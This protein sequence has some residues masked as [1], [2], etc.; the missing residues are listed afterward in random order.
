MVQ[1]TLMNLLGSK[2]C[3]ASL[4]SQIFKG[5]A[6]RPR[7]C[8]LALSDRALKPADGKK[9]IV[10]VSINY[11]EQTTKLNAILHLA[12]DWSSSQHRHGVAAFVQSSMHSSENEV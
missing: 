1:F 8:G 4:N 7:C 6:S 5:S 9:Y 3:S 12:M 11:L 10:H 2:R